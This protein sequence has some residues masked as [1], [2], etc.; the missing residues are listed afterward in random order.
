MII[1]HGSIEM[2]DAKLKGIAEW[3]TPT[4]LKHVRMFIGFCNFYRQ[5]IPAFSDISRPLIDLTK[6]NSP[7]IWGP[8]QQNAF[9]TIKRKFSEKP[10]L[11]NPDPHQQFAI[12]TD[13]SLVATGAILLQKD[14]NGD[15]HPCSYLSESLGDAERNYQIYDRELL[16]IVRAIEHWRHFL[17]GSPHPVIVFTDHQN[18]TFFREAQNLTHRQARWH[19]FLSEYDLQFHYVKGNSPVMAGPDA[20][21]RRPDYNPPDSDNQSIIVLPDNLFCNSIDLHLADSLR[22]PSNIDEPFIALASDAVNG[23]SSPPART[24]LRDWQI[25]DGIL[26]FRHRAYVPPSA[27]HDII[28]LHHDHPTAGHPG[29]FKTLELL[30]RSYWWPSMSTYIRNYVTGCATCQQMKPNTHPSAPALSPI[31]SKST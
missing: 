26:Y 2:D 23:L 28:Q 24:E 20:L 30:Q 25:I 9:D 18:L 7:F 10:V 16:A 15:Y 11:R 4:C 22:L 3:G 17:L 27:H 19:L 14:D 6:K 12:A 29:R 31:P 1:S 5:F 13:A 8:E 21:S